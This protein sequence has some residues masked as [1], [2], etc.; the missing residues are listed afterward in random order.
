MSS[1]ES[2]VSK[3][4]ERSRSLENQLNSKI[5]TEYAN[6]V[7][8]TNETLREMAAN[9]RSYYTR[10]AS[11]ALDKAEQA[12]KTNDTLNATTYKMSADMYL[13]MARQF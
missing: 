2:T 6:L 10:L 5:N 4:N 1:D 13:A 7:R 12:M 11:E 3:L 8:K 9:S